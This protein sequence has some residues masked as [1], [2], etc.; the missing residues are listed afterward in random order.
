MSNSA[1]DDI[2]V[3][4][5]SDMSYL[6]SDAS[7]LDADEDPVRCWHVEIVREEWEDWDEDREGEPVRREIGHANV[8]SLD[9]ARGMNTRL[10]WWDR[11]DAE[12]GDLAGMAWHLFAD[13][14]YL[15]DEVIEH[16]E[17]EDVLTGALLLDRMYLD[18]QERGKG[19]AL[20]VI[21][22][23]MRRL[24]TDGLTL[25]ATYPQPDGWHEMDPATHAA[26]R[27]K[28]E[29]VAAAAG[30]THFEDGHWLTVYDVA[31]HPDGDDEDD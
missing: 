5:R 29:R 18:E 6:G 9:L 12:T 7:R 21:R 31:D 2:K 26:A 11:L 23:I 22:H 24:G 14:T 1:W 10:G 15:R 16:V 8:V 4:Y 19:L 27:A 13:T 3:I 25:V 17:P 28:I 30:F 20:E